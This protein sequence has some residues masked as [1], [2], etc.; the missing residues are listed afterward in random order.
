MARYSHTSRRRCRLQAAA[1][2][3]AR[4]ARLAVRAA[5]GAA[6]AADAK[7]LTKSSKKIADNITEVIGTSLLPRAG[8][9]FGQAS[10]ESARE[11]WPRLQLLG[12]AEHACLAM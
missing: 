1:P 7:P 6:A 2:R 12:A 11:W 8:Q 5:E 10:A 3:P 4:C 9:I